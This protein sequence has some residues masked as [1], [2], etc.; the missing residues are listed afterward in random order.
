MVT[1]N[2]DSRKVHPACCSPLLGRGTRQVQAIRS[3]TSHGT[4]E[5][6]TGRMRLA[7]CAVFGGRETSSQGEC[8]GLRQELKGNTTADS[9]RG[10]E[11]TNLAH[12]RLSDHHARYSTFH[13]LSRQLLLFR[14]LLLF[15]PV[16]QPFC[17]EGVMVAPCAAPRKSHS[18]RD[19]TTSTNLTAPPPVTSQP[20][21]CKMSISKKLGGISALIGVVGCI[22]YRCQKPR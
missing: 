16:T 17:G 21:P 12:R 20:H 11:R 5:H 3:G 22:S 18:G 7:E 15:K 4:T 9:S 6:E 13:L 1:R 14:K 19:G 8:C 10:G 2:G